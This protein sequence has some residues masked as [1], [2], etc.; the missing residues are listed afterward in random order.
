MQSR[1]LYSKARPFRM[2]LAGYLF[3]ILAGT[4]LLSLPIATK[5]EVP[6]S[7]MDIFFTT[8]S[9]VTTSGLVVLDTPEYFSVFG[10]MVILVLIQICGLGYMVFVSFIILAIG[11]KITMGNT[12]LLKENVA[13]P[14]YGDAFH[15]MKIAVIFTLIFEAVAAVVFF[16]AF[17]TVYPGIEAGYHAVFQAV[18]AFCTAG[19]TSLPGSFM[20]FA[21]NKG[22]LF[23][24]ALV[25]ICGGIGFFVLYDM[26]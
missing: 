10:Q 18:S 4:I 21:D 6:A 7:L 24:A 15:F 3:F 9:A 25:S 26:Y 5:A 19:F 17:R 12:M 20:G 13:S 22:L 2:L 11:R 8:V 16:F 1:I 23:F 14:T